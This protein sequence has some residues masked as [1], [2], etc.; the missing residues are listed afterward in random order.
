[1]FAA[2]LGAVINMNRTWSLYDKGRVS[3][4]ATLTQMFYVCSW[5]LSDGEFNI[6]RTCGFMLLLCLSMIYKM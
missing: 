6:S 4:L 1:L 3:S 2:V 5:T